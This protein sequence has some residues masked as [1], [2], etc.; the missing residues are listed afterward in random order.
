MAFK[1]FLDVNILLDFVLQ[2]DGY[3]QGKTIVSWA[4][5]GK[6]AGFISPTVVQ[7][8]S[9]WIAKAYGVDKAK[10][11]MTTLLA[12]IRTVDTPHETVLTAL[13]SSMNDIE[14]A[15]L[16]YT[17]LHH[18]M[19]HVISQDRAFQKTALPSLPVVSPTDFID[20]IR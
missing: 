4:E 10:E 15:L 5:Q 13:H 20:T 6:I 9:Y 3:E 1:V 11:I 14:D 18:D 16:Y 2:R 17:A 7:I 12:F 19:T 8:C